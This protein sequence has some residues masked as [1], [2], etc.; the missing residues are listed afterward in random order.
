MIAFAIEGNWAALL[1]C[2]AVSTADPWDADTRTCQAYLDSFI[3]AGDCARDGGRTVEAARAYQAAATL[4]P[5]RFDIR[6]QL[7][8]MQKDSGR[9]PA[10]EA[11]YRA[12]IAEMPSIAEAHLQLGHTLKLVGRR[13]EA[14]ASYRRALQHDEACEPAHRELFLAGETQAQRLTAQHRRMAHGFEQAAHIAITLDDMRA[15]LATLARTL[16]DVPGLGA[17]PVEDYALFRRLHEIPPPPITPVMEPVWLIVLQDGIADAIATAQIAAVAAIAARAGQL[18]I[19]TIGAS[20]AHRACWE[21]IDFK[22][23]RLHHRVDREDVAVTGLGMDATSGMVVVLAPGRIPHPLLLDWAQVA[24]VH[25]GRDLVFFDEEIVQPARGA[26]DKFEPCGLLARP[27][28]DPLWLAQHDTAGATIALRPGLWAELQ[29]LPPDER[30]VQCMALGYTLGHVPYALVGTTETPPPAVPTGTLPA[31]FAPAPVP[32]PCTVILCTRDNARACQAMVES[33]FARAHHPELL[34]IIIVDN[35]SANPDDLALL[36]TLAGRERTQ[37]LSDNRVFNWSALNNMAAAKADT[38][39][40]LFCN[41]D[42]EML[43]A[44]WDIV[45]DAVLREPTTGAVGARLLYADGTMQHAGVLLGWQGSVI[46]D[47]LY[48]PRDS[49]AQFGRWQVTR[50]CSAVTGAFLGI[51]REVFETSGGFDSVR[52]PV[53][54]SDIDLCLRLGARGFR[55]VWTPLIEVRH[56]ESVSRGLDHLNPVRHAAAMTERTAFEQIWGADTLASDPWVNPIWADATLP[57]RLIRP[58]SADIALAWLSRGTRQG[59]R[60]S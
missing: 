38:P 56:D 20:S 59:M 23:A 18:D 39:N 32:E 16:P 35:G 29:S 8:N 42:M 57:W 30:I 48:E 12:V 37:V 2:N 50:G 36:E 19:M 6:L 31:P 27:T 24:L 1:R 25:G 44:G 11:T 9:I 40:L 58:V 28:A 34:N 4:A 41:D 47:G 43:A 52:M 22:T 3:A 55:I 5:W 10:A 60:R 51:R 26:A 13:S 17:Y 14:I 45:L 15:T 33:L 54:Y 7:G 53:A 21:T 46:H 49:T